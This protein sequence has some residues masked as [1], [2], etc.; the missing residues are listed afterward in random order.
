M[1]GKNSGQ[2]DVFD[3][4]I[5]EKLIPKDHLLVKIDSIVDFEF[6]YDKVVNKYSSLGRSSKDPAM[7]LK[8][9]VLEYLYKLSDVQVVERI[10]TD[11]AFRWFL[12]L[13]IDDTVPDDT[14][15]S[16]FRVNRLGAADFEE[17]F[18]EI[19][20]QCIE[21]DLIKTKRYMI[22]S[23]DVAANVNY[24][25]DKKIIRNA[26]RNVIKEIEK[27]D[28]NLANEQI[29]KIEDEIDQE[30]KKNEKV[31]AKIHYEITNK[32]LNDLYLDTYDE[33]QT[34]EKYKEAFGIC[35]DIIDQH[36]NKKGDKIISVVDPDAR[37]GHKSIGNMKRGYKNHIIAD[38]DSEIILA[39]IQTPFNV[40]DEKKL[41]ELI[42]KVDMNLGIKPDEISADKVYGTIEN[43]AYL[44][45]SDIVS[46]IAFY[47]E[48]NMEKKSFGL[49]D[50]EID[51]NLNFVICPNGIKSEEFKISKSNNKIYK[52]FVIK[53]SHC[54]KCN[55]RNQ[56][57][58]KSKNVKNTVKSKFLMV[59]IRYD[60]T[61]KDME[62]V[63]TE[64]FKEAYNKRYK[65]ERRFATLVSNHGLRRCRSVKISRA[66]IHITLANLACNIIRMVKLLS[67]PSVTM[68]KIISKVPGLELY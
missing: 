40:G 57:F 22:D 37:V 59:P 45:D 12:K 16:H 2:I 52:R 42:E 11:V 60:G 31:S 3:H 41:K 33:L 21:K 23:T 9:L 38:E 50:F 62:R 24:P 58:S 34:N 53:Q 47:K 44:K 14:T 51:E 5:F 27:F 15:I 48:P 65:V 46:N 61:L 35:H 19:V 54:D 17:F 20:R 28:E 32:Y 6:V 43:R 36:I 10:K 56:C 55:L 8:I 13:S 39:S 64:E 26:Y 1:L 66:K 25:S 68:P 49:K 7:M 4:L 30:Y 63:K 18:N 67:P 29:E